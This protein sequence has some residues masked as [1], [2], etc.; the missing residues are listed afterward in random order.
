VKHMPLTLYR[1]HSNACTKSYPQNQRIFFP[2]TNKLRALDCE[3]PIA[4]EG[5]L[6]VNFITNK[7]LHT[8]DWSDAH[9]L[10]EK[11][12][13]WQQ[14]TPP[15]ANN[16]PESITVLYAVESF[17]ASIGPTGKNIE[18]SSLKSYTVLLNQRL[19]PYC[20]L[21]TYSLIREFDNLD[22]TTKFT[23][24]WVNLNP[25]RNRKD[26][27]KPTVPAY[28]MDTTK[29]AQLELLRMFFTYCV[30][31]TWL[32]TNQAKKIKVSTKTEAKFGMEPH[33]EEWF[34]A[35]VA[36]FT[37]GHYR[38]G[39]ENALE[40]MTACLAM[41]HSG[42]RISDCVKLDTTALVPR[43]SGE[44]WAL[45]IFQKKTKEWV[46]IPI[47]ANLE[48]LLRKLPIKAE[49]D[50]KQFWFWTGVGTQKSAINN[51][52][53]RIKKIVKRVETEH[54]NFMHKVSPHTFRHTF[55]IRHLNAGTD[56]K[57]VSQWLGHKHVSVT[58]D[59]YSHAIKGTML[60]SEE[61]YDVSMQKQ[62]ES[63]TKR[64]RLQ[65]VAVKR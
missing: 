11:W 5:T 28:L 4:A 16:D 53:M 56:I 13:E 46:Y 10:A 14:T 7:A 52:Y 25:T 9:E 61:A 12:E 65:L 22:V 48:A 44:G 60:A 2:V 15:D 27:P 31:R 19:L 58:E 64:K 8:R 57:Q 35:E 3:C 1:R 37:D 43:A 54:G 59:H 23:E 51:L 34:F 62:E 32:K 24:S 29:K 6:G 40:L 49:K 20:K 47:P 21:K 63:D 36:K 55:S 39:Q 30:E 26:A 33:E 50:G 41:R 17:L 42:I 38:V 45:K 18:T